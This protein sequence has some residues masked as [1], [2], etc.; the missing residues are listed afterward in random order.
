MAHKTFSDEDLDLA[1]KALRERGDVVMSKEE[2]DVLK[3]PSPAHT[4]TPAGKP[5]FGRGKMMQSLLDQT[6]NTSMTHPHD[7][8]KLPCFSGESVQKGEVTY[9]VWKFEANCL[10]S[11]PSIAEQVVLSVM[12]KSLR[13]TARQMLIPLG[14]TASSTD[15]LNKFDTLF[16]NVSSNESVMQEFY[17]ESQREG[18]SV[19]SYSCRL[20]SLLQVA[21]SKGHVSPGSKNDMLRSKLYTG[22]RNDKLKTLTKNKYDTVSDFDTLLREIRSAEH[23]MTAYKAQHVPITQVQPPPSTSAL[24]KLSSQLEQLMT[25]MQ[26]LEEKVNSGN[27]TNPPATQMYDHYSPTHSDYGSNR[28]RGRSGYGYRGNSSNRGF[29]GN[30]HRGG[31]MGSQPFG[32]QNTHTQSPKE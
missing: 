12:R 32:R 18:E 17:S 26:T 31:H 1:I 25:K 22:L 4:S 7:T 29:R 3:S 8:P 10:V 19:T 28:G 24:D 14:E 15:I 5:P 11:D 9:D 20:E 21:V 6:L 13:G 27:A 2:F 16:G 23:N 30:L